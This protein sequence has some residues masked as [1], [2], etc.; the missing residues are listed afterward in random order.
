MP[1]KP[2]KSFFLFDNNQQFDAAEYLSS[3]PEHMLNDHSH[4]V[5][6]LFGKNQE[7]I[8][9]M[10]FECNAADQ[11]PPNEVN[12]VVL[13]LVG[14]TLL[15]CLNEYLTVHAI[16]RN[17][18]HC[19]NQNASQVT[20]FTVDPETIIFQLSRFRYSAEHNTTIKI[21]KEIDVPTR[22]NLP[23]GALYNIVGTI[24]H[25]GQSANSGHYTAAIFNKKN[26]NFYLCDDDKISEIGSIELNDLPRK[27]YLI[28]YQRQ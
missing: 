9:C 15:M 16:N 4:L 13:P 28:I 1:Q 6:N 25:Y 14:P 3:F 22:I 21:H 2:T 19:G 11:V 8:F 27:V 20:S 18:P 12:I 23:S 7:T 26:K 5:N 24:N 10:N 17:C